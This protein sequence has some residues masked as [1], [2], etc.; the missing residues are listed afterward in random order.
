M[1]Y[2][3]TSS[4]S[5][6]I[7][8]DPP[9][10]PSIT[11]I[12][13]GAVDKNEQITLTCEILGGNPLANIVWQCDGT[14]LVTPTGIP[15]NNKSVS[16]VQLIATESHN[17]PPNQPTD[18]LVACEITS[19]IVSWRPGLNGGNEQSFRVVWLNIMTQ[20]IEYSSE[21]MDSR[22]EQT[23]QYIVKSLVPD[24]SY[25]IYVEAANKHGIVRSTDNDNCTTRSSL[26]NSQPNNSLAMSVGA[27]IGSSVF[28]LLVAGLVVLILKRRLNNKEEKN[29][30]YHSM[31]PGTCRQK[32]SNDQHNYCE[33]QTTR[34]DSNPDCI[35][36]NR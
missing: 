20:Q 21:I 18:V 14:S 16:S 1:D 34:M 12:P 4:I 30:L 9:A 36:L 10:S 33:L 11:K 23:K 27:G 31:D 29:K 22:Q 8:Y 5:Q 2:V 19:M 13:H 17:G 26:Y 7:G 28:I 15:P 35:Q 3:C 32:T 24:T 25:I 6:V